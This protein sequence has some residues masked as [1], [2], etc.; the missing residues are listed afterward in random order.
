MLRGFNEAAA[1]AAENVAGR[2]RKESAMY[3]GF[4]EAAAEAAENGGP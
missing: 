4:N 3:G 2:R 1:E